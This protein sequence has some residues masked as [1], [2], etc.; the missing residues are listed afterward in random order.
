MKLNPKLWY[1]TD[2]KEV[3]L[4][5]GKTALRCLRPSALVVEN[6]VHSVPA[7]FGTEFALD[8]PEGCTVSLIGEGKGSD[9]WLSAPPASS[10]LDHG[11]VFT[12]MD[13][14][15]HESGALSETMAA[16][17]RLQLEERAMLQRMKRAQASFAKSV[18]AG[19]PDV[20]DGVDPATGEVVQ[21]D[22]PAA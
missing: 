19:Q 18:K 9:L 12:N 6:G 15:P 21:N 11:E 14:K 20:P 13:R 8:L 10:I 16:L 5:A 4:P 7:G 3:P 22:E 1:K 2:G 17:R